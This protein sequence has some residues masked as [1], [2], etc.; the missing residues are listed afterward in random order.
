[1][2]R[3]AVRSKQGEK[4]AILLSHIN[5]S[6]QGK[7]VNEGERIQFLTEHLRDYLK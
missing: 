7:F 3:R 6:A 5:R 2:L 4:S 1:V